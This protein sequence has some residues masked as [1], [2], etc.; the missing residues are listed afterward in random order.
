MG[1]QKLI[2]EGLIAFGLGA[3]ALPFGIWA[4]GIGS[5]VRGVLLVL[6]GIFNFCWG[7]Y[8]IKSGYLTWKYTP[9]TPRRDKQKETSIIY[10]SR[11]RHFK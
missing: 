6:L 8:L 1:H 9:K 4:I 2:V 10:K 5:Y 3:V 11:K 7:G